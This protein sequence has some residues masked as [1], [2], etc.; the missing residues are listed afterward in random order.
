MKLG[1]GGGKGPADSFTQRGLVFTVRVLGGRVP[2]PK[3]SSRLTSDPGSHSDPE[4]DLFVV[5]PPPRV[6]SIDF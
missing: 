1:G 5:N 6:F 4:L 2:D 3:S